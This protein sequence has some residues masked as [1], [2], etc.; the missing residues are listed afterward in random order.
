MLLLLLVALAEGSS[1]VRVKLWENNVF[2]TIPDQ[3]HGDLILEWIRSELVVS[4]SSSLSLRVPWS[5][6][7]YKDN[8]MATI[9]RSDEPSLFTIESETLLV[10]PLVGDLEWSDSREYRSRTCRF[11]LEEVNGAN[12]QLIARIT[13]SGPISFRMGFWHS[14]PLS[15]E[16]VNTNDQVT[17]SEQ[18]DKEPNTLTS[19]DSHTTMESQMILREPVRRSSISLPP[20]FV[21]RALLEQRSGRDLFRSVHC[22]EPIRQ[23][24]L[25][26]PVVLAHCTPEQTSD[27]LWVWALGAIFIVAAIVVCIH[28]VSKSTK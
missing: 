14:L 12:K 18:S 19:S 24:I 23:L 7:L 15:V 27:Y 1:S 11:L 22:E 13:V 28:Y 10:E 4:V 16:Q 8:Q 6:P 25:S 21:W 17:V 2:I 20:C 9:K 3:Y 5:H 26:G